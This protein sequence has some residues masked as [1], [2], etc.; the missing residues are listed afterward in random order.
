[1]SCGS[2]FYMTTVSLIIS[3]WISVK[4]YFCHNDP[5]KYKTNFY[6]S[7]SKRRRSDE[8]VLSLSHKSHNGL[9]HDEQSTVPRVV[10]LLKDCFISKFNRLLYNN[11]TVLSR[12]LW[13][14]WITVRIVQRDSWVA[15]GVNSGNTYKMFRNTLLDISRYFC[16]VGYVVRYLGVEQ[17]TRGRLNQCW[18]LPLIHFVSMSW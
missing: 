3:A 4:K 8:V 13:M 14:Y 16:A 9:K 10:S 1:M 5:T 6:S 17:T 18:S 15:F 12:W 2:I 11:G 7:Q